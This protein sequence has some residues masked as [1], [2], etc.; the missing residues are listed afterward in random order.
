MVMEEVLRRE[1]MLW[2]YQRVKSNGGALGVDG[3]SVEELGRTCCA[4]GKPSVRS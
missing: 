1:N 2:A 4:A 3:M